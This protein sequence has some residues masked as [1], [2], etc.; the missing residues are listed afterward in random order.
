MRL[1]E[2]RFN[3]IESPTMRERIRVSC[4]IQNSKRH[5]RVATRSLNQKDINFSDF[6]LNF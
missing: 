5:M 3:I 6:P 4:R 1:K 2:E